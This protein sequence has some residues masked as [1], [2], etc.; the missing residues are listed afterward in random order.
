[1][2]LASVHRSVLQ[3]LGYATRGIRD[4][5]GVECVATVRSLVVAI[6]KS[7]SV[8]HLVSMAQVSLCCEVMIVNQ[9]ALACLC[10]LRSALTAKDVESH[11]F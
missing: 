3:G 6:S 10:A 1:M 8:R 4:V 9:T 7:S 2:V 5:N 11:V